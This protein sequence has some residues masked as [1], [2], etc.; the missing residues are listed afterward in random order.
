M[1]LLQKYIIKENLSISMID[2]KLAREHVSTII[3]DRL[4]KAKS[5]GKDKKDAEPA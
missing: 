2:E 5:G 4:E 1:V 3:F